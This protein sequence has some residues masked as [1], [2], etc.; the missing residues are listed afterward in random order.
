MNEKNRLFFKTHTKIK[1]TVDVLVPKQL[2]MRK[3]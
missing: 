2:K 1:K 3:I